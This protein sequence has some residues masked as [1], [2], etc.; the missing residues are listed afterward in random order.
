MDIF[1]KMMFGNSGDRDKEP[2]ENPEQPQ[3]ENEEQEIDYNHVMNQLGS[4][5]NSLDQLKPV[6]KDLGLGSMVSAI[7]KKIM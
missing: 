2:E 5:M 6:F 7:K 4:I 3:K 1:T